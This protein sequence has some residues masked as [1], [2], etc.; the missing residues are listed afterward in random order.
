MVASLEKGT[1]LEMEVRSRLSDKWSSSPDQN[2]KKSDTLSTD[3][4]EMIAE[5]EPERRA[6]APRLRRQHAFRQTEVSARRKNL[7]FTPEEDKY[8][9]AGHKRHGFCHCRESILRDPE[10]HSQKGRT[11][12][13]LLNRAARRFGSLAF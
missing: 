2:A 6:G 8:L 4:V 1:E 12:N 3:K 11:A 9:K 7:M 10:L 5:Q 13:S